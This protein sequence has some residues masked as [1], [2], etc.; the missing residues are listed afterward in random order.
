METITNLIQ[1]V[2]PISFILLLI[3]Q[4]YWDKCYNLDKDVYYDKFSKEMEVFSILESISGYIFL[5]SVF[6]SMIYIYLK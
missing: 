1:W 5:F 3:S 2:M 6:Y 4:Y